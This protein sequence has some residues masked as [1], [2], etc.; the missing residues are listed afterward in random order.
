[1]RIARTVEK[2]GLAFVVGV[3]GTLVAAPVAAAQT[4]SAQQYFAPTREIEAD[5]F[6][7]GG[8]GRD[9]LPVTGL[10]PAVLA[11]LAVVLI[12]VGLLLHRTLRRAA[13]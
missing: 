7:P 12:A 2:L 1:M 11:V 9:E 3:L 4:P 5:V 10:E 6:G 13:A 8:G